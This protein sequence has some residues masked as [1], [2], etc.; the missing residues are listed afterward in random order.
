MSVSI[1]E[2]FKLPVATL[3]E[4]HR[5]TISTHLGIIMDSNQQTIM[6]VNTVDN[7]ITT[8]RQDQVGEVNNQSELIIQVT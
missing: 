8:A 2:C 5:K 4:M 7:R 1:N 3:I 6:G